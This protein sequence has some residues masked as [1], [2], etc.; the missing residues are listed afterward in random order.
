MLIQLREIVFSKWY[1]VV[2]LYSAACQNEASSNA[3]SFYDA[4]G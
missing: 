1:N 3:K 4:H 2:R